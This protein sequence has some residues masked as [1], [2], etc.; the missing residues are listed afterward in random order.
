MPHQLTASGTRE[1]VV[2]SLRTETRGRPFVDLLQVSDAILI[3]AVSCLAAWFRFGNWLPPDDALLATFL[4]PIF[5]LATMNVLNGYRYFN[6]KTA[7]LGL[8]RSSWALF[9]SFGVLMTLAYFSKSSEDFS[10]LWAGYWIVGSITAIGLSRFS[11]LWLIRTCFE[12]DPFEIRAVVVAGNGACRLLQHLSGLPSAVPFNIVRIASLSGKHFH[13]PEY[14]AIAT[15]IQ[16]ALAYLKNQPIDVVILAL[17]DEEKKDIQ[18]E[19][20]EIFGV[21]ATILEYPGFAGEDTLLE[22]HGWEVIGGVPF[23]LHQPKPFGERGQIVKTAEDY[24]LAALLLLLTAPLQILIGILVRLDS[25][26]P[27]IFVQTRHGFN[28]REIKVYKFRTMTLA[29]DD[30]TTVKQAV[31]NDPRITRLGS[32]LRRTSLDELPQLINV[33][34]GHMSLVGPRPHAVQHNRM[35]RSR[36]DAYLSRHRVKPGITGWAQVNG[37]R[38]ETDTDEKMRKRVQY[39]LYY[40]KNW[41]LLLDMQILLKTLS[42]CIFDKNAY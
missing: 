25:P 3:V 32:F 10:R 41:S 26:G 5:Y 12:E 24:L 33:L 28:G 29:A 8:I 7:N 35:Y 9:I 36:I 17:T 31:R 19:L 38:G 13:R 15:D 4:A 40:I 34:Q 21:S 16:S 23:V 30:E 39:D 20:D 22:S 18:P 6:P 37:W 2:E 1:M 11:T 42:V 27:A 14:A